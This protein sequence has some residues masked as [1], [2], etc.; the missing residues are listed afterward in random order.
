[1]RVLV[2]NLLHRLTQKTTLRRQDDRAIE[3]EIQDFREP[4][5]VG[6][7]RGHQVKTNWRPTKFLQNLRDELRRG[8]GVWHH[9]GPL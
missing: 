2:I 4:S 8:V 6:P 9:L 3:E 5:L 1:M 7:M